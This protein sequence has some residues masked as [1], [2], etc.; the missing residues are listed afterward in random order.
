MWNDEGW[1]CE[2]L[3]QHHPT[4]WAIVA[5]S[6]GSYHAGVETN[7]EAYLTSCVQFCPSHA[8][9]SWI[10]SLLV[11]GDYSEHGRF[12]SDD[13]PV[14]MHRLAVKPSLIEGAGN[15][16]FS[17]AAVQKG[18][19]LCVYFGHQ[20]SLLDKLNASRSDKEASVSNLDYA[21]GGFK[22]MSS[23]DP[24]DTCCIAKYV[25]DSILDDSYDDRSGVNVEFV[26]SLPL[27]VAVIVAIRDIE[28]DE[29]LYVSYGK[30]YWKARG[31]I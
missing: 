14:S 9:C 7:A 29:E 2:Q 4:L 25:N 10:A 27:G 20:I 17:E 18:D 24:G 28:C 31:V 12:Y 16:L 21:L 19:W 15:G 3:Q 22:G 13:F 5:D 26:R 30:G 1:L 11:F 8:P 6:N 23:I